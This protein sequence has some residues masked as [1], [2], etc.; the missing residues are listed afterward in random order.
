VFL[1]IVSSLP[2]NSTTEGSL[3]SKQLGGPSSLEIAA[4]ARDILR[5]IMCRS[6]LCHAVITARRTEFGCRFS[7][8]DG[9]LMEIS[10]HMR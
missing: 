10:T 3:G 6:P 9:P 1:Q 2:Q 8:D 4:A 7:S 5:A